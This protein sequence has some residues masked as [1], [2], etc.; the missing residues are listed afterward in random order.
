[1]LKLFVSDAAIDFAVVSIQAIDRD[2]NAELRYSFTGT[3][4]AY[5]LQGQQVNVQDY[6]YTNLFRIDSGTGQV[7]VNRTLDVSRVQR[8]IYT[9]QAVDIAAYD[10][11]PQIGTGTSD[12]EF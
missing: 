9:V 8:V 6:D 1:M 5:N 3:I 10:G 4:T 11:S 7:F 2:E 12:G